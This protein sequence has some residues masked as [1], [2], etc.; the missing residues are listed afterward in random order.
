MFREKLHKDLDGISPDEELLTKVTKLM[1]EEAQMPRPKMYRSVVRYCGMAAAVCMIAVGAIALSNANSV[2]TAEN[3][4]TAD[5]ASFYTDKSDSAQKDET[6]AENEF[7]SIGQA[8]AEEALYD[9]AAMDEA[10]APESDSL[11]YEAASEEAVASESGDK[12]VEN[13]G[14]DTMVQGED[15]KGILLSETTYKGD[16]VEVSSDISGKLI[17]LAVDYVK[18]NPETMLDLAMP[19]EEM[20]AYEKDGLYLHIIDSGRREVYILLGETDSLV[21]YGNNF[22]SVSDEFKTEI[23][24]YFE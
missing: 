1:Q 3:A 13:E 6:T 20:K 8:S 24:A 10:E 23:L 7:Y 5:S 4:A 11:Y 15:R 18:E 21:R 19:T 17:Q 22:Y 14:G 2:R 12:A 16:K 9:G